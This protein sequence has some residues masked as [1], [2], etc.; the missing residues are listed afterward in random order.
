MGSTL[1]ASAPSYGKCENCREAIAPVQRSPRHRSLDRAAGGR[2]LNL[3]KSTYRL[4][5]GSEHRQ[6][7]LLRVVLMVRSSLFITWFFSL[8]TFF[9]A[10]VLFLSF[11]S[12]PFLSSPSST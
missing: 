6:L 9:T 8:V 2:D 3:I 4:S 11:P 12:I 5:I 1:F 7:S 10:L